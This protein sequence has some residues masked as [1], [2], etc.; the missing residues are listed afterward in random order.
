MV[1][2]RFAIAAGL[3]SAAP[4]VAE[5]PRVVA[6][7]A[8]VHSLVAQVMQGVGAP[9]LIVTTGMSPHGYALRPSQA[10]ALQAADLVVWIGPELTPWL[11]NSLQALAADAK[12]M[13]L[14]DLPET[15]TRDMRAAGHEDHDGHDDHEGHDDHAHEAAHA[16]SGVDPHIWLDPE[17]GAIWLSMI[18]R[19]LAELDPENAAQYD[20]NAT[21]ARDRLLAAKAVISADLEPVRAQPFVTFHDAYQYFDAR[22]GLSYAGSVAESD[23]ADPSPA[24]LAALRDLLIAQ[25][26]RCAFREPQFNDR[27]LRAAIADGAVEIGVLDPIGRDLEPG[28]ELYVSLLQ[29]MAE[30]LT[31]CLGR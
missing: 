17:N 29:N 10:R 19:E 3:L 31:D 24:R 2:F 12:H 1:S 26:V 22:F 28:P 14:L 6:D 7:I 27:T 4:A 18:A 21:A 25:D 16:H 20:A 11:D 15:I 9:E 23:A 30:G 8:P 13:G 5:V